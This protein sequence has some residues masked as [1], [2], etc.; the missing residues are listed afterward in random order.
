MTRETSFGGKIGNS[1]KEITSNFARQTLESG[2]T[3]NNSA[4]I[5]EESRALARA[6][7]KNPFL[8]VQFKVQQELGMK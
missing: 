4:Y 8:Y 1:P 6:E 7:Q 2:Q 5:S 3:T